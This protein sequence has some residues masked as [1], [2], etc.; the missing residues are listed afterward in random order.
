M[1]VL[2]SSAVAAVARP[3]DFVVA[4]EWRAD[5]QH[6][7]DRLCRSPFLLRPPCAGRVIAPRS[8]RMLAKDL[9]VARSIM[10]DAAIGTVRSADRG[11]ERTEDRRRCC[12]F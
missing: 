11:N 10:V 1:F 7:G 5:R 2:S 8:S 6:L 12:L 4:S 9:G 3:F